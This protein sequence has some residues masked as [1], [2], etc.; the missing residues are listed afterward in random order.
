[1][2]SLPYYVFT[3]RYRVLENE[4]NLGFWASDIKND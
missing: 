4:S 3:G 2:S 1:M